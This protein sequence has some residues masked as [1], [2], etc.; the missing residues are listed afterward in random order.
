MLAL[1]CALVSACGTTSQDQRYQASQPVQPPTPLPQ[2]ACDV[3]YL[4]SEPLPHDINNPRVMA[5]APNALRMETLTVLQQ[6]TPPTMMLTPMPEQGP[7]PNKPPVSSPEPIWAEVK[8]MSA[9]VEKNTQPDRSTAP[10]PRPMTLALNAFL[11]HRPE[12]AIKHLQ[13][14]SPADQEFVMRMLPILSDID[15]A[16]LL[17]N[18]P[19]AE[20]LQA[21]LD[22][23][24]ALINDLRKQA[25]L[26]M[27]KLTFCRHCDI[28]AYGQ[29]KPRPAEPFKPGE[30]A[31][32]YAELKNLVDRADAHAPFAVRLRSEVSIHGVDGKQVGQ[33]V[34]IESEPNFSSSP[35]SD[36]FVRISFHVPPTLQHG[37]Y[38]VRVRLIDRDT[39]RVAEAQ[40][41]FQ[42]TSP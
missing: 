36:F 39:G 21:V 26:R 3:A 11:E 5:S 9:V 4:P 18:A 22:G 10:P 19:N 28:V 23:L 37:W 42:I 25:P 29:F 20:R 13:S 32:L 30:S 41:P 1:V 24:Q 12:L 35:R 40:L 14:Y 8:P 34:K 16:G 33:T 38:T 15:H 2:P 27:E 31:W 6:P 17:T 7:T